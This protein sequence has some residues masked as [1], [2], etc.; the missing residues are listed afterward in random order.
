MLVGFVIVVWLILFI[1]AISSNKILVSLLYVGISCFLIG[2][3]IVIWNALQ[4][5]ISVD[6]QFIVLIPTLVINALPSTYLLFYC[7]TSIF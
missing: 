3:F 1:G 2:W 6:Y 5:T 4:S 7:V